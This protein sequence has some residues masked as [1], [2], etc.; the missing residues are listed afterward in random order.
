MK[1][2]NISE[3]T[4]IVCQECKIHNEYWQAA[5]ED[6]AVSDAIIIVL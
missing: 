1:C 5:A 3:R 4:L 2:E 6:S